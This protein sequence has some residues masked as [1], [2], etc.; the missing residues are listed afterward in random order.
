MGKRASLGHLLLRSA[1]LFNETALKRLRARGHPEAQ[2]GHSRSFPTS[3]STVPGSPSW[4]G[5]VTKQA[6]G[7]HV[8]ELQRLGVVERQADRLPRAPGGT[9]TT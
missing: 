6:V 1:R 9:I 7:Q 4:C 8:D 3:I 5:V 2:L